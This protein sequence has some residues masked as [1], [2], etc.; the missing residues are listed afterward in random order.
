[1]LIQYKKNIYKLQFKKPYQEGKNSLGNRKSNITGCWD[2]FGLYF[3]KENGRLVYIG[4]SSHNLH[5]TM[6][7]HFEKWE[8]RDW[9]K[10]QYTLRSLTSMYNLNDTEKVYTVSFLVT[11]P[12][13][14]KELEKILVVK[15]NPRD[16]KVKYLMYKRELETKDL[17][18]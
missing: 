11:K 16:N 17:P 14:E 15:H 18:F 7:R 3:I 8:C 4:K 1:M 9:W 2:K 5:K 12:G 13:D 10:E 6:Y